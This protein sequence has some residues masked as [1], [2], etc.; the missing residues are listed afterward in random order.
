MGRRASNRSLVVLSIH[1]V[2]MTAVACTSTEGLSTPDETPANGGTNRSPSR[3]G[4]TGAPSA[5][6]SD[7]AQPASK[8]YCE[9]V[10]GSGAG[11]K[12]SF[13]ADFDSDLMAGWSSRLADH[14]ETRH[15]EQAFVAD[16]TAVG[17]NVPARAYL[18]KDF[19]ELAT[20]V[21]YSFSV[22]VDQIGAVAN[23][24]GALAVLQF[25]EHPSDYRIQLN[26]YAGGKAALVQIGPAG[27]DGGP[28]AYAEN[29]LPSLTL[30]TWRRVA[31]HMSQGKIDVAMDGA[32]VLDTPV[33]TVVPLPSAPPSFFLGTVF[34]DPPSS[35]WRV[36]FD[37]VTVNLR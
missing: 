21:D 24:G 20:D 22:R 29:D 27:A 23:K 7:G 16:T 9:S 5:P 33:T 2:A 19:A 15:L 3:P 10:A 1:F 25:G 14:G 11:L 26:L 28:R 35:P 17:E 32:I 12:A 8:S 13:C 34:V 18:R 37:D 6:S 30:G 36:R 31:I 4:P